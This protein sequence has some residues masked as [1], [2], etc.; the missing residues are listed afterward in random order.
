MQHRLQALRKALT[1][2]QA[3]A[4]ITGKPVNR[5]YISGF[6]GSAGW[7]IVT[8]RD[9]VLLTDFRYIDQAKS[10]APD[11]R[12]INHE[13]D[14]KAAIYK[15]LQELGVKRLAFEKAHI[16]FA[17]YEEWSQVFG[18][19]ELVPVAGVF[20]QI[21]AV[22]DEDELKVVREAVRIADEAFTHILSYIRPGVRE[23]DIALELEFFMRK[24]GAASSSFD[25]IVASGQRG[26]LPHGA[27]S[28]KEIAAGEL[29]TLDYGALY[30]GYCSDI[31]RT[32]AVGEPPAKMR[33]IYE[34]V[35]EAQLNGVGS[36]KSGM[37]GKEADALTRDIIAAAGYGA[38][39]GHS[40]G[41]GFGLEVHEAP[42]LAMSSQTVLKPGMLVT[43]EPGIYLSGVGGVRI[44]DDV[45]ITESGCE[46]LTK[47]PKELLILPV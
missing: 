27:A 41:H 46:I 21:R 43:V 42:S 14:E 15:Q 44:E 11:F 33:E 37:T 22:K 8:A 16:T 9:A 36:I 23:L 24:Q 40:T 3:D 25:I 38:E 19:V 34:I 35:L 6:T 4:I 13:R 10:E 31:T 30:K 45:L 26:A 28:E 18:G 2:W 32:V 17:T 47:S 7:V 1:E 39:F 5:R 20:E 29:V 12:V